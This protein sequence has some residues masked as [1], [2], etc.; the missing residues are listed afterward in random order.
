MSY[1]GWSNYE[2]WLVKLW[3]D[4]EYS[5][6]RYWQSIVNEL[7]EEFGLEEM[8][9]PEYPGD[10]PE[11]P[12]EGDEELWAKYEE[13]LEQW[14][15]EIQDYEIE[16]EN[17]EDAA[18]NQDLPGAISKLEDMLKEWVEENSP[19]TSGLYA[20]LLGAAISEVDFREIAQAMMED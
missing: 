16:M 3:I 4:N 8:E 13:E 6:Y 10:E 18:S 2:T 9:E 17:Y 11:M 12:E 19:V 14:E 20:D 5:D 15:S 7:K 1:S